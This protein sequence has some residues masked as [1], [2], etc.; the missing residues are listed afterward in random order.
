MKY[1]VVVLVEV[2]LED[3]REGFWMPHSGVMHRKKEK[4]EEEL[5]IARKHF[6]ALIEEEG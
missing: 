3:G 6:I 2:P 4:A 5:K 1:Y